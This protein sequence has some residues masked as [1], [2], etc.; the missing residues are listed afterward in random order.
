MP[1]TKRGSVRVHC[2]VLGCIRGHVW[3]MYGVVQGVCAWGNGARLAHVVDVG[4]RDTPV[5]DAWPTA[6]TC[7]SLARGYQSTITLSSNVSSQLAPASNGYPAGVLGA[8][9]THGPGVGGEGQG[10]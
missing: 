8:S 7:A 2:R 6:T 3:G 9:K 10:D 5:P 4:P 1:R